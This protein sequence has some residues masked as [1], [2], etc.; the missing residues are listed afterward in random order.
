MQDSIED[1]IKIAGVRKDGKSAVN[2]EKLAS[3]RA[4]LESKRRADEYSHTIVEFL[5]EGKLRPKVFLKSLNSINESLYEDVVD[6]R[7]ITK[8]CGYPICG[9]SIP[10]IPEKKYIILAK[11]NKVYDLTDR[12]K[13]CSNFC[14]KASTHIKSQIDNSP[15]WLRKADTIYEYNLLPN[16]SSGLTPG[17]ELVNGIQLPVDEGTFTSVTDFTEACLDEAEDNLPDDDIDK[18][19]KNTEDNISLGKPI[20][21]KSTSQEKDVLNENETVAEPKPSTSKKVQFIDNIIPQSCDGDKKANEQR[22]LNESIQNICRSLNITLDLNAPQETLPDNNKIQNNESEILIDH[23]KMNRAIEKVNE[24]E[25]QRNKHPQ[26]IDTKVNPEYRSRTYLLN[27]KVNPVVSMEAPK[28]SQRIMKL[29]NQKDTTA[30]DVNEIIEKVKNVNINKKQKVPTV[31]DDKMQKIMEKIKNKQTIEKKGVVM[32]DTVENPEINRV[33][34]EQVEKVPVDSSNCLGSADCAA[35]INAFRKWLTIETFL[36]I[37]G[38]D[39]VRQMINN[40]RLDS[41]FN[42]LKVTE[43]EASQQLKYMNICKRLQLN[44]MLDKK[45]DDGCI[46]QNGAGLQPVPDYNKLKEEVEASNLKAQAFYSGKIVAKAKQSVEQEESENQVVLPLVETSNTIALRRSVYNK[47]VLQYIKNHLLELSAP[48]STLCKVQ[49]L[50]KTFKFE[51]N[52][53]VFKP[54]QWNVIALILIN[55]VRKLDQHLQ[56]PEST[57]YLQTCIEKFTKSHG[58]LEET[59]SIIDNF[60]KFVEDHILGN[61]K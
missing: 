19:K 13:Y 7:A 27:N 56:T 4:T 51:A 32:I 57:K 14:Y 12:K 26:I 31:Y 36:Y 6:E 39:K 5:I 11:V 30:S 21:K 22:E 23:E 33:H 60:D 47:S 15:L 18:C 8:L 28:Y 38:E 48:E 34:V 35:V 43:L 54:A 17:E 45:Y 41:Y 9:N 1:Y 2:Q 37:H 24:S 10:D 46:T 59:N 29:S 53:V 16:T 58:L 3:I 42:Q 50:I 40:D 61:N 25:K 20:L 55:C 44:E 52:N 49:D